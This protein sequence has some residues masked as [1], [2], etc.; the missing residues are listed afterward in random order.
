MSTIAARSYDFALNP[1]FPVSL[2]K[3]GLEEEP[4]LTVE[5]IMRD[6]AALIDYA[7]NE[8]EFRP[9]WGP[10]GGY[11]GMRAPAPLD[12]VGTLVRTLSPMI[13]KAFDLTGVKLAR[14]ECN[15]SLVTLDADELV[16]SQRVPHVDTDDALQFAVL[17][18]LCD[19]SFG[20]TAFYRHRA[21]GFETVTAERRTAFEEIQAR[22]MMEAAPPQR[23]VANDIAHYVQTAAFEAG[24]DRLLIY[25]SRVLHSG[26]IQP[27][28]KLSA[29]PREGRLTANIFVN[30][31]QL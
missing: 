16:P 25:R 29:A 7:A 31:R 30:Y 11:P 17:H 6:P 22:E 5:T 26:R 13:E 18:Y 28:T 1:S 27:G 9:A 21:T 8:V 2:A 14:A 19:R 20:G 23:Y 4:V 3:V 24:L 12:Y 15:F 10:S